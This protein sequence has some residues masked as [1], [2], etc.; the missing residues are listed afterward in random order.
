MTKHEATVYTDGSVHPETRRAGAAS[1]TGGTSRTARITNRASSLQTQLVAIRE[2]L[3]YSR[4]HTF[5]STLILT[6]SLAALQTLKDTIPTDNINLIIDIHHIATTIKCD[7]RKIT[8]HWIPSHIR[9]QGN[10][11]VDAATK[12]ASSK[13]QIDIRVPPSRSSTIRRIKET[14]NNLKRED[15]VE[16]IAAG[17]PSATWYARATELQPP[18]VPRNLPPKALIALHRIRLGYK[19]PPE[20]IRDTPPEDCQHCSTIS[21]T[22]LLHY[23]LECAATRTVRGN[24]IPCRDP[25]QRHTQAAALIARTPDIHLLEL[26]DSTPPPR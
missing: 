13:P 15:L 21:E 19:T 10:E 23:L 16:E 9:I 7:G 11:T 3:L 12:E 24:L 6:D 1:P 18:D 2:A 20:I 17:S 26:C 4:Q 22:P 8:L 14:T 5:T 25:I